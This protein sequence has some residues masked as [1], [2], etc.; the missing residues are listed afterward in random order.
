M[1]NP[2]RPE[3]FC[4]VRDLKANNEREWFETHR[5][6][7]EDHLREPAL[8]FIHQFGPKLGDISRHFNAI[9]KPVGGSLFRI[10]RDV[11]FSKDKTPYKTHVGI[12]FRHRQHRDAHAP[13]FYLHLEPRAC[14]MGCGIW[15]PD[16]EALAA[17]RVDAPEAR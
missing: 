7:F 16:R 11:R 2:L 1:T 13:G 8:E 10:Y 17:L 9:P 3:L 15:R 6:R 14:F 4:F 5:S 12:H